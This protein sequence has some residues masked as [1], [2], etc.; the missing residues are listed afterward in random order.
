MRSPGVAEASLSAAVVLI[1]GFTDLIT[2]GLSMAIGD[3]LSTKTKNECT[4]VERERELWEVEHYPV[5]EKW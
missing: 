4:R 2:D 1:L 5:G 3:Y